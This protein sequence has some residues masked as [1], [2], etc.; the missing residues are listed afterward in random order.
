MSGLAT[1]VLAIVII[2]HGV[3]EVL[4]I[5]LVVLFGLAV[6]NAGHDPYG[7]WCPSFVMTLAGF[8]GWQGPHLSLLSVSGV[9]QRREGVCWL[10][11]SE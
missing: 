5:G 1:A 6:G 3:P 11:R 9:S 7:D 10:R 8:I 4:A 2:E